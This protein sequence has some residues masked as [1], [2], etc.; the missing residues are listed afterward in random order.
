MTS[1]DTQDPSSD[2]PQ[3]TRLPVTLLTGFLGVGKTT[4]LNQILAD[5]SQGK[6]AVIVNE[7]GEAGLDHDLIQSVD[8]EVYLMSSGCL[9]CSVRDDLSGA[10][11]DLLERR[12]RGAVAFEKIVIETT[13]MADPGP[14][15][16]TLLVDPML[17]K[18]T[19]MD[20]VVTVVDAANGPATLDAQFEAVSQVAMADLLILSKTDLVDDAAVLALKRRLRSLN[21]TARMV[22]YGDDDFSLAAIWGLSALR[23]V[24]TP[25]HAIAWTSVPPAPD[26]LANLSGLSAGQP[27]T[28]TQ[29]AASFHDT[30]ITSVSFVADHPL[31]DAAFDRWLDTLI[32][33][34]G[35]NILRVKGIVFL[36]GIET[37]F[38]FHGVQHIFDPPVLLKSWNSDDRR[39]RIVVI[40]R[41][42]SRPEMQLGFEMLRA[43]NSNVQPNQMETIGHD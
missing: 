5:G 42:V 18:T 37:P 43:P 30:R 29:A 27:Q 3:D 20:G 26:P 21:E 1:S 14:I 2:A 16:Q 32:A 9:C 39:S 25:Q 7:F 17:A 15:L 6:I 19:R 28:Q 23:A 12:A 4:L 41:D 33:M 24:T 34:N 13:G 38:V 40:G 36:K 31:D 10:I 11:A 22:A 35:R 8:D